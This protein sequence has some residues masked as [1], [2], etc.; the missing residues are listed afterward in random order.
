LAEYAKNVREVGAVAP[1][2]R[3]LAR[4]MCEPINFKNAKVIVEFG[5]GTGVFS[6]EIL[7]RID[8]G[9]KLLLIESNQAF[10]EKLRSQFH[11]S[12]V[13][14]VEHGNAQDVASMLKRHK[15]ANP[16]V[17]VSGL[18]FAALPSEMSHA[19]LSITAE[20]LASNGAFITFQYTLLKKGLIGQ[21]FDTLKTTRELRNIPPAY[22]LHCQNTGNSKLS[23]KKSS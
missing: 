19:I 7:Q 3:Y 15:L 20:L 21:Y 11:Q 2:S 17:I 14:I 16:D 12:N 6:N 1:S 5:P 9:T 4:K 22:V 23:V 18:P 8:T 10:Y 13:V